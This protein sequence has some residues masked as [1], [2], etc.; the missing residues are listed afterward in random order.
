M[1][2]YHDETYGFFEIFNEKNGTLIRGDDTSGKDPDMRAYPELLDVGIMGHCDN[3]DW[4]LNAGVDCY[5]KADDNSLSHM[6]VSDFE[7]IARQ[8]S[9]KTFQIALGGAGDPNKHP[10]FE[11]ILRICRFYNIVPN[12]TTS[13]KDI[14]AREINA[15]KKYCG[16]VA[17]SWY[18]RLIGNSRQESN[19]ETIKTVSTLVDAGC[20]TNIHYVVSKD[21]ID[22]AIERLREDIFPAGV[23]AVV[24]ILYKPVGYGER[25]KMIDRRQEPLD[26][27]LDLAVAHH[28][29][30]IGFDTCFTS[31][32]VDRLDGISKHSIDAC[33]AATFSMYIDSRMNCYPCSFGIWQ[34]GCGIP[35][36]DRRIRDVWFS[37]EFIRVRNMRDKCMMN[38]DKGSICRGGCVLGLNIE[39][40]NR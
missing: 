38:C 2:V 21:T 30:R 28:P 6:T 15:I 33:E 40:C 4:C 36:K 7:I 27:F 35:C 18:S 24:F 34:S 1:I 8:S 39:L 10:D 17:V 25:A 12:I 9:G 16:A 13:G 31:A 29:Y 26:Q 22:E 19:P 32:L 11:E 14:T 23:H 37:D 5:Q 20:I 3:K